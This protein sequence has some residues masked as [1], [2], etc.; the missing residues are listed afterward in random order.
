MKL[1]KTDEFLL[2][3]LY[4]DAAGIVVFQLLGR[5]GLVSLLFTLTFP[6]TV[7]LWLSSV[8]ETVTGLDLLM[9]LTAGLAAVSVL[10]DAA[11]SGA[12]LSFGYFRKLV[13]FVMTLLFFQTIHRLPG[14]G[15]VA[16]LVYGVGDVLT[17]AFIGA[18][19]L[20][21]ARM[22][23]IGGRVSGYLT[24]GFTN[25]NLAAMIL[26][27]LYMLQLGRLFSPGRRLFRCVFAACLG[28]LVILTRS[29]NCLLAMGLFTAACIWLAVRK[30][31]TFGFTRF[32]AALTA[33]LP[34]LFV[35]VYAGL[36]TADWAREALTFLTGEG[37]GLDSRMSV[38]A[39]ALE[40]VAASPLT[41]GY[42]AIS[43][44]TGGSQMHN[45]HL[46]I[47]AS[48]GL[49]VLA[50]VCCL[51][52]AYLYRAGRRC[53]EKARFVWLLAF[54]CALML[55]IGEAAVFSGGLGI[56]LFAGMFLMLANREETL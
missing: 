8:R 11:V 23:E 14:S 30:K 1:G 10:L 21:G 28:Y 18:F 9:L 40:A 56:Y 35:V 52:G 43:G 25:P 12:S 29:R 22:Y 3:A 48:Y 24:F 31:N 33:V 45:T 20:G 50:L 37:K 15:P 16:G 41:G 34:G 44:G 17:A 6:L 54:G 49:P 47:A 13:M 46:D 36:V 5:E 51:L 53:G 7:L 32:W 39:P 19:F 42:F 38:W 55:G 27:C 26:A 2:K 4:L